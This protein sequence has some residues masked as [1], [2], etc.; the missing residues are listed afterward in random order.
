MGPQKMGI[1]EAGRDRFLT[2]FNPGP[3]E[4]VSEL[5]LAEM[6]LR[7]RLSGPGA[8]DLAASAGLSLPGDLA[9]LAYD[10]VPNSLMVV[11][12]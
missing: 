7:F 11:S 8:G 6:L 1:F 2:F 9:T 12:N 5:L 10:L 3:S 4:L